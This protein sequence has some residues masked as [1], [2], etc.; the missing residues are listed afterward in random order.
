MTKKNKV[1]RPQRYE[2]EKN[3]QVSVTIRPRYRQAL[4]IIAKDRQST[5]S[6]AIEL[7]IS[8]LARETKLQQEFYDKEAPYIIDYV[9]PK[10]EPIERLYNAIPPMIGVLYKFNKTEKTNTYDE[11]INRL[12]EI[13]DPL[14]TPLENHIGQ[15]IH[16]LNGKL[17]YFSPTYLLEAIEEDWK[18]GISSDI[19][20]RNIEI[21]HDFYEEV[22][23]EKFFELN[24]MISSDANKDEIENYLKNAI[25][26]F[27]D[28]EFEE[29]NLR[30]ALQIYYDQHY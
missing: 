7:A 2:G 25:P 22:F 16:E 23:L 14:L 11:I 20:A 15:T 21:V 24:P 28:E 29:V 17:H 30:S 6:E 19:T 8:L 13:P 9:R 3:V 1:G 4:E 10:I 5:L 12:Y 27:N 26:P 18:E